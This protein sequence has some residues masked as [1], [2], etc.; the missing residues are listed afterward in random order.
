MDL[1]PDDVP[2]VIGDEAKQYQ[3]VIVEGVGKQLNGDE[4]RLHEFVLKTRDYGK[5]LI[6]A[7]DFWIYLTDIFDEPKALVFLPKLARLIPDGDLR[8][9]LLKAPKMASIL[10]HNE[11]LGGDDDIEDEVSAPKFVLAPE[12]GA[13]MP[14]LP[15]QK[16]VTTPSATQAAAEENPFDDD[17]GPSVLVGDAKQ[18]ADMFPDLPHPCIL[19]ALQEAPV[20]AVIEKA[21]SGDIDVN[22]TPTSVPPQPGKRGRVLSGKTARLGAFGKFP[23]DVL[24]SHM[25][26]RDLGKLQ[27]MMPSAP[28]SV[29]QAELQV[30]A[31]MP[32]AMEALSRDVAHIE[33][34]ELDP[35]PVAL[36]GYMVKSDPGGRSFNRRFFILRQLTGSLCYAKVPEDMDEPSGV[37]YLFNCR[38]SAAPPDARAQVASSFSSTEAAAGFSLITPHRTYHLF[39]PS[40][41]EADAWKSVLQQMAML[42]VPPEFEKGDDVV[43]C[44]VFE[45]ETYGPIQGWSSP[46]LY[47]Q[48][49]KYSNR[50]GELSSSEFP[51]VKLPG[52]FKWEEEWRV[53]KAYTPCDADGWS[54]GT[55]FAALE[56]ALE[57]GES[58][59]VGGTF[60]LTR[61]RR[62]VRTS[63]RVGFSDGGANHTVDFNSKQPLEVRSDDAN[64]FGMADSDPFTDDGL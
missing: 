53:D 48:R 29:L 43:E 44:E 63:R 11:G 38:I 3:S 10:K 55:S 62:W 6:T 28:T 47:G 33:V 30:T 40:Q 14:P 52:D 50:K 12:D 32:L 34:N 24:P 25:L 49:L 60:D 27:E 46:N 35:V 9:S 56:Q 20:A 4:K 7:A 61:R 13:V 16:Q 23:L 59:A 51:E 1:L 19:A 5:G 58:Q 21:L 15:P 26:P 36:R 22:A 39:P 8:R 31:S 37:I 41:E 57:R 64:A 17:E 18:V 45:N 2:P 54:Y 42:M